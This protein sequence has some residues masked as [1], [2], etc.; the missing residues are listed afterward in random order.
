MNKIN[1]DQN[2]SVIPLVAPIRMR[3]SVWLLVAVSACNGS[4]N[5]AGDDRLDASVKR[6]SRIIEGADG[7]ESDSAIDAAASDAA[8]PICGDGV[9]EGLEQCDDG[10]NVDFDGCTTLCKFTCDGDQDCDDLNPCNG[11]EYCSDEHQCDSQPDLPDGESCG[12]D[13]SCIGGICLPNACGDGITRG[14]EECD[15]GDLNDDN[16]C[17]RECLFTCVSTDPDRDCSNLDPCAGAQVC[18]DKRHTCGGGA[19]LTN[20][21]SCAIGDLSGWC[22]NGVCVPQ[23]C[24]DGK[25]GPSEECDEGADNGTA[26]SRCSID[27]HTVE[28]GNHVIEGEEQCDDGNLTNLDGCDATCK[29]E[30]AYR[31]YRMDVLKSQPPDFCVYDTNAF[32]NAFGGATETGAINVIDLVNEFL[33]TNIDNGTTNA[34]IQVLDAEDPTGRTIDPE[35]RLGVY[36]AIPKGDWVQGPPLDFEFLVEADYVKK[37]NQP[38]SVMPARFAGSG[39]VMTTEPTDVQVRSPAGVFKFYSA[40]ARAILD[41]ASASALPSD[42][43][44]IESLKVPEVIGVSDATQDFS[45]SGGILCG[46]ISTA[47]LGAIALD[48]SLGDACCP[49][50][51]DSYRKCEAGEQ[52]PDCDS[53]YDL[54]KGGCKV[55]PLNLGQCDGLISFTVVFP[56]EPDVDA[57]KDGV[58]DAYSAVIA[59]EGRRA[60]IVGVAEK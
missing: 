43:H 51:V 56:S 50:A 58:K 35:V 47:S 39:L 60:R 54:L 7:N 49:I 40:M 42:S 4:G 9:T 22:M 3:I 14:D 26:G 13:G 30:I 10:N 23:D 38:V 44:V 17:T 53:F 57:N 12:S 48:A 27:C 25:K 16:G 28:C 37:N 19:P 24:G 2:L 21:S 59:F 5:S 15:D 32:G 34:L 45:Q 55:Y 46:A 36:S 31:L 52:P 6:D 8:E 18:S 29:A 20:K 1:V 41:V 33:S 11:V